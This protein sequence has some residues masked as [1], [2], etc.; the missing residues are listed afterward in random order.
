MSIRGGAKT[1]VNQCLDIC[2]DES[3]VVPDDGNEPELLDELMEVLEE[4]AGAADRLRY[5]EPEN[6]GQEP[7]KRVA[8]AM[9]E[10]DVFIAPTSKSISHTQARERACKN[11][12]RGATL[13]GITRKI[14]LT[15]LQADYAEVKRLS[16]RVY[17]M[18]SEASTVTIETVSGTDLRF[19]VDFDSFH[20]DTGIAHGPKEFTNL[21]AGEAHGGVV[22]ASGE[23]VVDHL[24]FVPESNEGAV[25]EIKGSRV[26]GWRNIDESSELVEALKGVEGARNV[27]EFGFGTNPEASIVGNV[28]QDEKV[29]G[30]VH[31][32]V[33]DN[34]HYFP[35]D[36]ERYTESGIHWD[37]VCIEPTV[38][39]D[40]EKV[41]DSGE[42][43]FLD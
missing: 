17:S 4:A 10:A 13:P 41:L 24:P 38:F 9:K 43:V 25:L 7:P 11:G 31:V 32:A 22:N 6:H 36:S 20:T 28:L 14:W 5:E 30:T 2:G 8:E 23:L 33:G 34:S 16:E 27:A 39:F 1:V 42:P 40:D 35:R 29:L 18:L 3:V 15:S 12:S 26:E 37:N 21:P 19:D